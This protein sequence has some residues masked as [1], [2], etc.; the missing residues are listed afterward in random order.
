MYGMERST[1]CLIAAKVGVR[2]A[3]LV[4]VLGLVVPRA[5]SLCCCLSN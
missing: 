5:R 4:G 1:A 2:K 3:R